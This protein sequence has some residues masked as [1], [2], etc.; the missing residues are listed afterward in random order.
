[1]VVVAAPHPVH[2]V[3][4]RPLA[5]AR[6]LKTPSNWRAWW[7][8]CWNAYTA[9][10]WEAVVYAARLSYLRSANG[11]RYCVSVYGRH[12][13]AHA[14][15]LVARRRS[16]RRALEGGEPLAIVGSPPRERL[17]LVV[18]ED[19]EQYTPPTP[20]SH[21]KCVLSHPPSPVRVVRRV[22]SSRASSLPNDASRASCSADSSTKYENEPGC[23]VVH[24]TSNFCPRLT[25]MSV[26]V[27]S[28]ARTA[29]PSAC[30]R[31]TARAVLIRLGTSADGH[32]E[33]AA[34]RRPPSRMAATAAVSVDPSS[35][36]C[37]ALPVRHAWRCR[38]AI[39]PAARL[40][41]RRP[42]RGGVGAAAASSG[43]AAR[44]RRLPARH[45]QRRR[46]SLKPRQEH[47]AQRRRRRGQASR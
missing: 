25:L 12:V 43:A 2:N 31:S 27:P 45:G 9:S 34:M 10:I 22:S 6:E 1:M 47:V 44:R 28:A 3:L 41:S 35:A 33:H 7:C 40:G 20:F 23:P 29:S 16:E 26:R 17:A 21:P 42:A 5:V 14:A 8:L 19:R 24:S 46:P 32:C 30:E 15:R 37:G 4:A 11:Y 39:A 13:G 38:R 36:A 18:L